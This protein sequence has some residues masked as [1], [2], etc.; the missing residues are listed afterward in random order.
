MEVIPFD[1]KCEKKDLAQQRVLLF[2]SELDRDNGYIDISKEVGS[3]SGK[4]VV[5]ANG[6][7]IVLNQGGP[8]LIIGEGP[9]VRQILSDLEKQ[10][11]RSL[12]ELNGKH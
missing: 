11:K 4:R 1:P 3:G 9:Q 7:F 6:D 2:Y 12:H 8:S 10:A 5:Y